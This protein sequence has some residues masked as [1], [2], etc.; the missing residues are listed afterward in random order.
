MKVSQLFETQADL[1]AKV[2]SIVKA[3]M[4]VDGMEIDDIIVDEHE[5]MFTITADEKE[6]HP[7]MVGFQKNIKP[8]FTRIGFEKDPY[9][10][11]TYQLDP[12]KELTAAEVSS[13]K[14][15]LKGLT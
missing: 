10:G 14:N 9:G 4:P 2:K 8:E 13:I 12:A 1:G 5:V 11:R 3:L 6:H 15:A 7:S